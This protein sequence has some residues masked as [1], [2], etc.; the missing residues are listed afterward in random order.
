MSLLD[1]AT[2]IDHPKPTACRRNR[3]AKISDAKE[4][5]HCERTALNI[6]GRRRGKRCATLSMIRI[7]Y[8]QLCVICFALASLRCLFWVFPSAVKVGQVQRRCLDDAAGDGPATCALLQCMHPGRFEKMTC[9]ALSTTIIPVLIDA[10]NDWEETR[11]NDQQ[12]VAH[13][14]AYFVLLASLLAAE[15]VEHVAGPGPPTGKKTILVVGFQRG[16]L[17]AAEKFLMASLPDLCTSAHKA[18]TQNGST[19]RDCQ[20][21]EFQMATLRSQGRLDVCHAN[22]AEMREASVVF[23]CF[24]RHHLGFEAWMGDCLDVHAQAVALAR[25]QRR[26]YVFCE[27]MRRYTL[28]NKEATPRSF[29]EAKELGAWIHDRREKKYEEEYQRLPSRLSILRAIEHLESEHGAEPVHHTD[30]SWQAPFRHFHSR[31]GDRTCNQLVVKARN[32]Y[33]AMDW[34][35]LTPKCNSQSQRF[36]LAVREQWGLHLVER[37]E[38]ALDWTASNPIDPQVISYRVD[39][40]RHLVGESL[41]VDASVENAGIQISLP[42]LRRQHL[43]DG[44]DADI[45]LF[46]ADLTRLAMGIIQ[47]YT[48]GEL[49]IWQWA[50]EV[51]SAQ[52]IASMS[53]SICET[54]DKE[55]VSCWAV[56]DLPHQSER[57]AEIRYSG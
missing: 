9:S 36:S 46:C 11:V 17:D 10:T 2:L 28:C 32:L 14:C 49:W 43:S 52:N 18:M 25:G 12:E 37:Q 41:L 57:Q 26:T 29:S 27:D 44:S 35:N 1:A 16:F 38:K 40:W 48:P 3:G 51:D 4:R 24:H 23:A 22:D 56:A 31:C 15:V 30:T 53:F 21:D 45:S 7:L 33:E 19:L 6:G 47:T 8:Q 20:R 42:V 50:S 5:I 34:T 13:S 54:E 55:Y 39:L